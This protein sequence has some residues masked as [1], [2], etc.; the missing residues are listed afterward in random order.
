MGLATAAVKW[1]LMK[2]Y[3]CQQASYVSSFGIQ[4]PCDSP[5]LAFYPTVVGNVYRLAVDVV[6]TA[7]TFVQQSPA[8][9]QMATI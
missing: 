9:G 7:H 6:L 3:V 8:S 1:A 5:T 2:M 4:L